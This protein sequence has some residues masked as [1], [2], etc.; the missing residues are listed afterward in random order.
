MERDLGLYKQ[1]KQCQTM[2]EIAKCIPN[3]IYDRAA[4]LIL[5]YWCLVP[6]LSMTYSY[7]TKTDAD[8]LIY[9]SVI[10]SGILGI[11]LIILRVLKEDV[12]Q[13]LRN[14]SYL[15]KHLSQL[16]LFFML[17]WSLFS[18]FL[19][20]DKY[21]AFIGDV[22]SHEGFLTYM[23]YAGFYGSAV[24]LNNKNIFKKVLNLFCW[25]G[26][27][28]S[29]LTILQYYGINIRA[30]SGYM[31]L[32]A[33]FHNTNHFGY[34]LT[35]TILCSGAFFLVAKT[36]KKQISYLLQFIVM[37]CALIFNNTFG[38]YLGVLGGS[39]IM[40]IIFYCCK[41]QLKIKFFVPFMT[42][43]MISLVINFTSGIVNHNF[44]VLKQ[45]T[46]EIL[47]ETEQSAY[48]GSGRWQLWT[49]AVKFTMERPLFGYGPDNLD[50]NY[51]QVGIN[52]LKP[53]NEYL[54][55]SAT[56]GLPALIFYLISLVNL[57][58]HGIKHKHELDSLVII[59]FCVISGYLI[60]AFV[61]N[62]KF[63]VT[64]YFM[65]LLALATKVKLEKEE[66]N[67]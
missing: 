28:L 5:L 2:S 4:E 62:T 21:H 10:G 16:T 20:R 29:F 18:C 41:G 67:V 60:S 61:G 64:P 26:T 44:E 9:L 35:L 25:V 30:F 53:H 51:A 36:L 13:S 31:K 66:A 57:Y 15:I 33:T 47:K 22:Y 19:A 58:I 1:L 65:I 34:Y 24:F 52:M 17:I 11:Y 49:N 32:A 8:L 59:S 37:V 38:S 39:L 3:F 46:V 42:L 63:Y 23:A 43:I 56:L 40:I 6:V 7:I 14:Q 55:H 48:A 54:Q 45:D 50:Y 27:V 12:L